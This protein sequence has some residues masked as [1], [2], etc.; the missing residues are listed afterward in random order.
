MQ[1]NFIHRQ[2]TKKTKI[3]N[4]DLNYDYYI[5]F[6]FGFDITFLFIKFKKEYFCG[7]IIK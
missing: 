2:I 7:I 1:Y 6:V 4:I 5:F 3:K